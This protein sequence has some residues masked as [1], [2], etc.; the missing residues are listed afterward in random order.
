MDMTLACSLLPDTRNRRKFARLVLGISIAK[1]P[2]GREPLSMA[3][4][5]LGTRLE[6]HGE[7]ICQSPLAMSDSMTRN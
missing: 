4:R 5:L 7:N 2:S 3:K 1:P 6:G